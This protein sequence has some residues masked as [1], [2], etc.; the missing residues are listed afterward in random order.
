M[1]HTTRP[2]V[3]AMDSKTRLQ[4]L[5]THRQNVQLRNPQRAAW[6]PLARLSVKVSSNTQLLKK[7]KLTI[8]KKDKPCGVAE[9]YNQI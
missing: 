2:F 4:R 8:I 6:D 1:W 5:T 3:P 7:S 9:L